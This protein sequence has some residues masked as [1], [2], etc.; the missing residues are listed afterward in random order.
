MQEDVIGN[1]WLPIL[2]RQQ[3]F[4]EPLRQAATVTLLAAA[5]L[6]CLESTK[7]KQIF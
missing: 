3:R 2:L 6:Y 1:K 5:P 4:W 7:R